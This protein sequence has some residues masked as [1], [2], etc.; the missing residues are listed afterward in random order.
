M[1]N[2]ILGMQDP[3]V[4]DHIPTRLRHTRYCKERQYH[5]RGWHTIPLDY[6]LTQVWLAEF[7]GES[8]LGRHMGFQE[9]HLV[10][11]VGEVDFRLHRLEGAYGTEILKSD[12]V[13]KLVN[14]STY[15]AS[16]WKILEF[17]LLVSAIAGVR[18]DENFY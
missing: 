14:W 13:W 1:G 10:V 4:G 18:H 7:R 3:P 15:A 8:S 17:V 5:H 16:R 9:A 12:N 11:G 2:L 6:K